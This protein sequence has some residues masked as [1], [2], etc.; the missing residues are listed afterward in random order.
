[1]SG[2]YQAILQ[3][4]RAGKPL[5]AVLV[6]PDKFD[7]GQ[8]AVFLKRI[9]SQTTHILV[10]GSTMQ[11]G[12]MS[13]IVGAL[14]AATDLPVLLF[15][16]SYQQ[17]SP[18]ADGLLFLSLLSGRNAE[19]LVGQQVK[20]VPFLRVNN[21]E[22]IPTAYL[23]I[24]G[25]NESAVAQVTQTAPMD[26]KDIHAIVD[27]AMAGQLMGAKMV[28]LEAGSGAR[29][30]VPVEV[31]NAVVKELSIPVIVGGGIR[32]RQQQK[33]AYNAGACMVVIGTA[34]EEGP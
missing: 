15:P 7:A 28:Y 5:L 17:L 24:D 11:E 26:N 19:Y 16:G 23:L 8:T 27:T 3:A 33:E 22:V 6:D 18:E 21:L 9:P 32:S 31:I 1:M 34:L 12:K 13:P 4:D 20:A 10:G 30:A 25:G 2:I 14:K 29:T